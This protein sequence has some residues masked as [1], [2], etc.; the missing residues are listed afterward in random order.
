MV[1][2]INYWTFVKDIFLNSLPDVYTYYTLKAYSQALVIGGVAQI[3]PGEDFR[4]IFNVIWRTVKNEG[5]LSF[6]YVFDYS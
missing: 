4:G 3:K 5:V 1:Y 2:F 6:W